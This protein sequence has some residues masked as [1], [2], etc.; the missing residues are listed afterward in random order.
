MIKKIFFIITMAVFST[1]VMFAQSDDELFGGGD[2]YD[3][4]LFGGTDITSD[5]DLFGGSDFASD[6]DLFG[7]D[8][9]SDDDL[10]GD[11]DDLF[12]DDGIEVI[13]DTTAKT[14]SSKGILFDAGSI[15]VG[16]SF[17]TGLNTNTVLYSPKE[18]NFGENL[19]NSTLTP[20]LSAFLTVDA[21][22]AENLRM[23][24]KFGMAYP[25]VVSANTTLLGDFMGSKVPSQ[26]W[27]SLPQIPGVT[28]PVATSAVT[29]VKDWFSLKELFTDFSVADTAFFRFGLHTVSWGAGYFF[30]PVSDMIN[31]SSIDPENPTEQVNG[32][33][34]LRTQ[35]I[36]PDT[37]NCLWL[38]MIPSTKFTTAASVE[39]YIRDT[40]LAGKFDFVVGGWELG[41][42][43]F[44]KYENAPK[45]MATF[46]GSLKKISLFGEVVYQ[47]GAADEWGKNKKW[48]DKTSIFQATIGGMYYW[49][50]PKINLAVQYYFDSN[51]VD[52]VNRLSTNGHNIALMASFGNIFD[53]DKLS[54]SVFS[55]V[56]FGKKGLSDA[57]KSQIE[58]TG[59]QV[60]S[61]PCFTLNANLAYAPTDSL[62]FT[63]GP[64]LSFTDFN[65][66]PTVSIKLG[67]TLGG[68]NF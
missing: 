35:I 4:E 27:P 31:T 7:G 43:A 53:I 41:T 52:L 23:Y 24:T 67:A 64:G 39:S 66:K 30:S 47:Y 58:K 61:I 33:L 25:F 13:E 51:D 5:D 42:G 56:N 68:G 29:A 50:E 10:F 11:E 37:R 60:S 16:G 18:D 54:A 22:P 2:F 8:Y 65:E 34:N 6:D 12:L 15:K 48:D 20:N 17:R 1:F 63:F 14:N 21:R 45:V 28:P 40:G 49:K 19:K 38:Y 26:L 57:E 3:E 46:S 32:S 36:F 59:I 9:S 55:I 44:W 62:R